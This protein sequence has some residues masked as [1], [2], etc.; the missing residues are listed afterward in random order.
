M[1]RALPVLLL[2]V[3]VM[4]PG[5]ALATV[6]DDFDVSVVER[7]LGG[8]DQ[9]GVTFRAINSMTGLR[10]KVVRNDGHELNF[11]RDELKAGETWN[12]RWP[13][14]PGTAMYRVDFTANGL[15]EP[16]TMD[17]NAT[18]ANPF[19]ITVTSDDI[20][21]D[22]GR[23]GFTTSGRVDKV[24]FELFAPDGGEI[25]KREIDLTVLAGHQR[26]IDYENPDREIGLVKITA[27]DPN[28][29]KKELSFTPYLVPIPHD[30]VNFEFG[31]FD[32]RPVEERKLY[33]V[34]EEAEK[35]LSTLGQQIRFKLYV[36]GYTDTV[37][38]NEANIELSRKRAAAI[39]AWLREHGMRLPVCSRGFGESVLAVETGD[40]TP[41]EANRRTVFVISGQAPYGRD[42]P[43]AAGWNCN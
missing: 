18:V 7:A 24:V 14:N 12:I 19:D 17:F 32:I 34:I 9:P 31:M 6:E 27:F 22:A 11:H 37:G 5:P 25:L 43:A 1:S 4:L 41:L 40:N 26:G 28:G 2:L 39:A 13:Q 10:V 38:S 30:E 29:F 33:R 21:L 42:F 15:A 8:S 20:D 36:A 35:A 23:I 3:V 16:L